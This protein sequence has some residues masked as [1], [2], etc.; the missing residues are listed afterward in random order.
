VKSAND[1]GLAGN[2]LCH[3]HRKKRNQA[4]APGAFGAVEGGLNESAFD[5][6]LICK[7]F[8]ENKNIE[9]GVG[10][11]LVVRTGHQA[12]GMELA[13]DSHACQLCNTGR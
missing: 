9:G 7:E 8:V 4:S 13:A 12:G 5:G 11:Y 3:S 2:V 1:P 10:G 6:E